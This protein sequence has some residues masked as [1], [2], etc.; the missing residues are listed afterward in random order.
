MSNALACCNLRIS[1]SI[2][3]TM[4]VMSITHPTATIGVRSLRVPC[5]VTCARGCQYLASWTASYRISLTWEAPATFLAGLLVRP[6][7]HPSFM[8]YLDRDIR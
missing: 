4:P 5:A 7:Q 2:A 3:S 6:V 8:C 1:A